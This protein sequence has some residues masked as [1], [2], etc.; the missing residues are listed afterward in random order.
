MDKTSMKSAALSFGF[1]SLLLVGAVALLL[2]GAEACVTDPEGTTPDCVQDV[3]EGSHQVIDNGCNQFAVCDKGNAA[4]CCTDAKGDPLAGE[5]L[6]AC[7]Y[8]YG[9]GPAP[10]GGGGSS[11]SS[12]SSSGK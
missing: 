11:S 2:G 3:D 5:D 9:A 7:L 4:A 10:G 1:K 6:K 8:G 12:S